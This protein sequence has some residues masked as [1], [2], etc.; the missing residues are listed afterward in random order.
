MPSSSRRPRHAAALLALTLVACAGAAR[1]EGD[2]FSWRLDLPVAT[3]AAIVAGAARAATG[4][5]A[6]SD[7]LGAPALACGDA[8]RIVYVPGRDGDL[9]PLASHRLRL[10]CHHAADAPQVDARSLGDEALAP[11][12][13]GEAV[14]DLVVRRDGAMTLVQGTVT[15][16][17][18][19]PLGDALALATDPEAALPGLAE[20]NLAELVAFVLA[21]RGDEAARAG[22]AEKAFALRRRAADLGRP[23]ALLLL[24]LGDHEAARGDDAGARD[25]YLQAIAR[26]DEPPLRGLLGARLHDLARGDALAVDW[27]RRAF[28]SLGGDDL[29]KAALL[30]HRA[31]RLGDEPGRDYELLGELHRRRTEP[32]AAFA[33]ELLAREHDHERSLTARGKRATSTGV[34]PA[35]ATPPR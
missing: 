34:V 4:G 24:Q 25:H 14:V 8:W 26:T 3:T 12:G 22:D 9:E 6:A 18:R 35:L 32:M 29:A 10:A 28:D 27:R 7:L 33:S 30:L 15:A 23:S 16:R 20:P 19:R 5:N 17:L 31:R 2:A 13:Y 1:P 11:V 21:R